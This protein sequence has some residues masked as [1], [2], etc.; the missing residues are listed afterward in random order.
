M[1]AHGEEEGMM[2]LRGN[3]RTE[4]KSEMRRNQENE[5]QTRAATRQEMKGREWKNEG[6]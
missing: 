6:R 4:R 2:T 5:E 3:K 1:R